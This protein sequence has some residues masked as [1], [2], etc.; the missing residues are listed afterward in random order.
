MVFIGKIM[1][2]VAIVTG[3]AKRVGKAM[4]LKLAEQN[5]DIALHYHTSGHAAEATAQ[6]I[7]KLG[8]VCQIFQANLSQTTEIS[9]MMSHIM[10]AFNACHLLVNNASI[11]EKID[12]FNTSEAV[13]EKDFA[14]NF[15]AP[16]FLTQKFAHYGNS[17]SVINFL[18]TRV[19]KVC[20]EHFAYNL[21]KHA[22]MHFTR[23]AAKALAPKIR[24][25]AICLGA[26]LPPEHESE[27]Y[28]QEIGNKTPL[29]A[30]VSLE[31]IWS[32]MDYLNKASTVTG[33]CLFVD[34][35]Q[36]LV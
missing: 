11:F 25:N 8:R 26:V 16:F 35:G 19:S 20:I 18:D 15:K 10:E 32:A 36:H 14:I 17:G 29:K 5:Y 13:L 4:A 31:S 30:N 24:V 21:S 7:R 27:T 1:T 9:Q 34:S 33:E 22:L 2:Q 28:L 12:F 23:M 6:E 3:G